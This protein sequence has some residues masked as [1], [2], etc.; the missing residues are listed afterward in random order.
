MPRRKKQI[1]PQMPT[2]EQLAKEYEARA[3]AKRWL[4]LWVGIFTLIIL[5]LWGWA[6]KI[7]LASFSWNK[8]PEKKLIDTSKT[9]WNTLFNDEA[10]RIKNERMKMQIKDTLGKLMAETNSTTVS[11]TTQTT[12]STTA[13]TTTIETN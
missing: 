7:S 1:I 9:E 10:S 4:W 5:I 13:T 6:T 12:S 2:P 11:S 8:T 3:R